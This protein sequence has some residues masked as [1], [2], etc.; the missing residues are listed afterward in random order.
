MTPLLKNIKWQFIILQKDNIISI[1]LA[2]TF[3]Y[4]V[5]GYFLSSLGNLDQALMIMML[6]DPTVIG[7]FFIALS[8]YGERKHDIL[9]A[10][11]TSPLK[12]YHYLI[13]K[14]IAL[15]I[16]GLVC[17]LGLAFSVKGMD[18]DILSF[19]IGAFGICIIAS[20]L[21][22][23]VMTFSKDFL[24][25]AMIS[26]PIFITLFNLPLLQYLQVIDM[27]IFRY[28]LPI[29]GAIDLLDFALSGNAFNLILVISSILFWVIS[30]F[31]L[32]FKLFKN[33]IVN[34]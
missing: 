30:S 12:I 23:A 13:S 29:Q 16:V 22:I 14:T 8:I 10:L 5:L 7:Y 32:A 3:I 26:L 27:G 6:N 33:K 17:S 9:S 11:F 15:S 24:K 34:I 18:F 28:L 1:S 19:S 4:G 25:F 21:G 20:F 2:V 31:I